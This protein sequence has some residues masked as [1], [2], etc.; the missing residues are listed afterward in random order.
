VVYFG[1]APGHH[2]PDQDKVKSI[3]GQA[4]ATSTASEKTAEKEVP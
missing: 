4:K 3:D 1:F 2:H